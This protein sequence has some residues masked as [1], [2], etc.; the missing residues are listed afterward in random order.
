ML[1]RSPRSQTRRQLRPSASRQAFRSGALLA[2]PHG[3]GTVQARRHS[4]FSEYSTA[5]ESALGPRE[6]VSLQLAPRCCHAGGGRLCGVAPAVLH[7][8]K[9]GQQQALLRQGK[10]T[11]RQA[12]AG[13]AL[14]RPTG[15]T[16]AVSPWLIISPRSYPASSQP[17]VIC[18]SP[19]RC[20]SCA[21]AG[22]GVQAGPAGAHCH[23]RGALLQPVGQRLP[24]GLQ[25]AGCGP[26]EPPGGARPLG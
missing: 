12:G 1:P 2:L 20:C 25:E 13:R 11:G 14:V 9:G 4:C 26:G 8:R 17:S 23:R 6:Q 22:E 10:A 19:V 16:P 24:P 21:A 5:A 3:G 15:A 7:A 18:R